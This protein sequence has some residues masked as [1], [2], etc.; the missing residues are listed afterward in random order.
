MVGK[1]PTVVVGRSIWEISV[2]DVS[3]PFTLTTPEKGDWQIGMDDESIFAA[4]KG[5]GGVIF[6]PTSRC[7]VVQGGILTKEINYIV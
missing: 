3:A 6:C 4:T 2:D 7:D 1:Q 5:A